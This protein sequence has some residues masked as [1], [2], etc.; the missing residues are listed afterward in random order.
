MTSYTDQQRQDALDA[1]VDHGLAETA[2]RTGIPRGTVSSWATR[3]GLQTAAATALRARER[4]EAA[5]AR[6]AEVSEE[7]RQELAGRLLDEV[8]AL[9]DQLQA[10]S[11]VRQVVVLS[12]GKDAPA[13][14]EVADVELP[15][16]PAKDQQARAAA[17][18][19]LVDRL[20]LLS[21]AVTERHSTDLAGLDLEAELAHHQRRVADERADS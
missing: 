4:T 11:L 6:W 7:R 17:I 1:Y 15:S 2:R 20:Q 14:W 12:G 3:A 18:G 19:V 21:G 5:R 16:P 10:P 9:A 13:S 8:H